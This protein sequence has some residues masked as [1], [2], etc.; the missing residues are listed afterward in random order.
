MTLILIILIIS[1]QLYRFSDVYLKHQIITRY[2]K[3]KLGEILK[4]EKFTLIKVKQKTLVLS[5]QK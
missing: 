3:L 2:C 5:S 4:N 1:N